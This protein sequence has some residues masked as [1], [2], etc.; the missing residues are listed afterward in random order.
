MGLGSVVRKW[1]TGLVLVTAPFASYALPQHTVFAQDGKTQTVEELP[2]LKKNRITFE[3]AKKL[4]ENGRYK[5]VRQILVEEWKLAHDEK[6]NPDAIVKAYYL[7]EKNERKNAFASIEDYI[8]A[9]A[10]PDTLRDVEKRYDAGLII[11]PWCR[12]IPAQKLK[13]NF[14]VV[15]KQLFDLASEDEVFSTLDY[16]GELTKGYEIGIRLNEKEIN[17]TNPS[18]RFS[19]DTI[20]GVYARAAQVRNILKGKRKVSESFLKDVQRSYLTHL[21]GACK[22]NAAKFNERAQKRPDIQEYVEAA[23]TFKNLLDV[24]DKGVKELGY[25]HKLNEKEQVYELVKIK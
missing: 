24:L 22:E 7:P 12:P 6:K 19:G 14:I 13:N 17:F 2:K 15:G 16:V 20:V 10:T 9:E 4:D 23:E 21:Y 18:V 3:Q 5:Y 11:E 25:E 1:F 8:R